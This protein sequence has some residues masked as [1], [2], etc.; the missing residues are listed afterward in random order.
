MFHQLSL[1][2]CVFHSLRTQAFAQLGKS[3][4]FDLNLL[5]IPTIKAY[6]FFMPV[7]QYLT[8]EPIGL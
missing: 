6:L 3:L 1:N 7:A 2:S 4:C 5:N 8:S